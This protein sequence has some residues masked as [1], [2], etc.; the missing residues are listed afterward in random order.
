MGKSDTKWRHSVEERI[1]SL[2]RPAMEGS[3]SMRRPVQDWSNTV[4]KNEPE[5]RL[6]LERSNSVWRPVSER[7]DSM[8][9]IGI[10]GINSCGARAAHR[11]FVEVRDGGELVYVETMTERSDSMWSRVL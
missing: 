1:N 8:H 9:R 11:L 7:N 6:I 2:S 3:D 4:K 5:Q 10:G